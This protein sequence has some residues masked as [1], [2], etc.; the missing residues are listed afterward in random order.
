MDIGFKIRRVEDWSK[1]VATTYAWACDQALRKKDELT[2]EVGEELVQ[3]TL[4]GLAFWVDMAS[5]GNVGWTLFVAQK[6]A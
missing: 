2:S 4:D 3:R 1:H 6:P 5:R